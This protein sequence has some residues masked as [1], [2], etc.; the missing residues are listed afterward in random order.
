MTLVRDVM[1][2]DLKTV[3]RNDHLTLADDLMRTERIRH[4]LVL[5]DDGDLA[6]V[7]S[8]RDL[9]L[10]ALVRALGFG[11]AARDRIF[12]SLLIKDVM[13]KPVETTTPDTALE[14][15]AAVMVARQ[16]GCLPVVD[17]TGLV[18]ILTEGDFVRLVAKNTPVA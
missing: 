14:A 11:A 13:T 8:Q 12:E 9:F 16:I 15:A 3:G 18:G 5:N 1:S 6:G 7:V 10:S 4:L 2:T 17:P